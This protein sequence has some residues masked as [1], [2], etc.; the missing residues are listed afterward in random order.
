MRVEAADSPDRLF[1]DRPGAGEALLK[2]D[3]G[4][5]PA[6][7]AV[8]RALLAQPPP[9]AEAQRY[10]EGLAQTQSR[11]F[12]SQVA[13]KD[14]AAEPDFTRRRR[15]LYQ[16]TVAQRPWDT[17]AVEASGG[18]PGRRREIRSGPDKLRYLASQSVN[19]AFPP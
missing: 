8:G 10:Y 9:N 15:G 2:L 3:P 11:V 19:K 4:Y 6:A 1:R 12:P 7:R 17:D 14:I 13:L 5:V 16:R 18:G